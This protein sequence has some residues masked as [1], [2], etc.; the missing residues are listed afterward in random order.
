MN[1]KLVLSVLLVALTNPL[2]AKAEDEITAAETQITEEATK[3][4]YEA[5]LKEKYSLTDEQLQA[6]KDSKISESQF[7]VVGALSKASGKTVD[8]ILKMRTEDKMGWGKI[9]KELGVAPKEIGQAVSGMH[10]QDEKAHEK[11]AEKKEMRE[12]RKEERKQMRA[13]KKQDRKEARKESRS[14]KKDKKV[15]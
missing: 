14:Q 7:A 2:L 8:E 3:P 11:H 12:A 4:D 15:Q 13:E 1:K 6:M 5:R 10:R 9:A